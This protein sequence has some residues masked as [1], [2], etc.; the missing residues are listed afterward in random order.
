MATLAG[1]RAMCRRVLAS[2]S[3]WPDA[4]VNGF[5]ADAVRFY[6][7]EFPRALRHTLE[8]E[9]GTQAYALPGGSG[10]AGV[11]GVEYPAGQTPRRFLARAGLGSPRFAA[12]GPVYA[13]QGAAEAGAAEAGAA[14]AEEGEEDAAAGQ[15][16]FAEAVATGEQALIEYLGPH[17][18]PAAD[19][20]ELTLPEAHLEALIAFVD[21]RCH[22]ARESDAAVNATNASLL[23]AQLGENGRRAWLRYKE[24]LDRL[25]WLGEAGRSGVVA[26]GAA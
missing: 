13:L 14:E 4:M 10:F 26:W 16:V 3:A 17:A 7:A 12:G 9:T 18:A 5:I 2:T 11:L 8:L 24:V 19:E 21:F 20:D 15:I 23:L 1:V 22:W 25:Q 6:S